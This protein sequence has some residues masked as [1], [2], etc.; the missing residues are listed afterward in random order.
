MRL[1]LYAEGQYCLKA[2]IDPAH[3]NTTLRDP[4]LY[5]IRY[6]AHPHAKDKWCI[7]PLYDYTHPICDSIEGITHSLCTLEFEIRRELY[8]WPL[9][10]LNLYRPM[11]W[12]YSR[13]NISNTVLSKR[14][15]HY[16]IFN[17]YVKS[18][19][20]PRVLTINGM[21][22]RGYTA[23]AINNFC[24]TIGVTRRGNENVIGM[25]VLENEVRK[26]LDNTAPRTMAV[27]DPILLV[28][29]NF[30]E[31][32]VKEVADFPKDPNGPKHKIVTDGELYV[33]RS[34]VREVDHPTF[35][36]IAPGKR[37]GLKYSSIIQVKS[38]EKDATGKISKI[39]ALID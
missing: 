30:K 8:Y 37:V 1:G 32:E 13:L 35:Y 26:V 25:N 38:V 2:K 21:K 29:E 12:E 10:Q 3:A 17:G 16:L 34:D 24:D 5:R 19:D 39:V 7:Y 20:D 18:W 33:D 28:L 23:E 9:E 15:L 22:R 36:G 31:S 4:V 6:T 11:V 27:I 14:K